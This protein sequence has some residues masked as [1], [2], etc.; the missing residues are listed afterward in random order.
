MPRLIEIPRA[1]D[2]PSP[3]EVPAGDVLLFRASGGRV[4]D[5]GPCVELWGPFFPAIVAETGA[6]VAPMGS[7]DAVLVRAEAPGSATLEIFTGDPWR[8]ARATTLV[9]AVGA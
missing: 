3:L 8:E 4:L 9:I 7:P 5:G 2:C 6:V 1:E